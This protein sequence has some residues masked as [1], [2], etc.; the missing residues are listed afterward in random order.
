MKSK[1]V[2]AYLKK[3]SRRGAEDAEEIK[4]ISMLSYPSGIARFLHINFYYNV[5]K[6]KKQEKHNRDSAI[7]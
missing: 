7:M 5:K 4:V 6:Y 3:S 2:V 1:F